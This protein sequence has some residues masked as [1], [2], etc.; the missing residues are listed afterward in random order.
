MI[1]DDFPPE[2]VAEAERL[3]AAIDDVRAGRATAA[4][5]PELVTLMSALRSDPPPGLG[6]RI[7]AAGEEA[8][9]SR[10]AARWRPFSYAAAVVAYLLIA[11]GIGNLVWGD[12]VADGVGEGY[13]PHA[14]R[15][16][17]F[18]LVAVGVVVAASVFYRRF[19]AVA[20]VS[21]VPLSVLLGIEGIAEIGRFAPGAILHL[22]QGVAGLAL[23]VIFFLIW[24]DRSARADE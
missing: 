9:R 11:Q 17:A 15:E 6:E 22:C 1:D 2:E 14:M 20:V 3:D 13:S 10:A 21:A 4:G 5:D 8:A 7:V 16:A 18:A 23:G 12:W 24:R 19:A